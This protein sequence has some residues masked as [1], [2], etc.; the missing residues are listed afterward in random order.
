MTWQNHSD[1]T[2]FYRSPSRSPSRYPS[3][4][5]GQN[6][7]R[8]RSPDYYRGGSPGS[9]PYSYGRRSTSKQDGNYSYRDGYSPNNY[10]RRSPSSDGGNTSM[11]G[12]YHPTQYAANSGCGYPLTP[13]YPPSPQGYP[14]GYPNQIYNG[15]Q[16]PPSAWPYRDK[17]RFPN[18]SVSPQRNRDIPAFFGSKPSNRATSAYSGSTSFKQFQQQNRPRSFETYV[19]SA[20]QTWCLYQ[21]KEI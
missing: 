15:Y 18:Q 5:Q 20:S 2:P 16:P 11:G 21:A 4:P 14:P 13:G 3:G 19:R 7:S 1:V 10:S 6:W 17:E 8:Q 12:R 9:Q